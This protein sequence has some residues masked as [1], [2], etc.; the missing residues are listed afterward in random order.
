MSQGWAE[1][2]TE[3]CRV[4]WLG[5]C[6]LQS[7]LP[8]SVSSR[9]GTDHTRVGARLMLEPLKLELLAVSHQ[10]W[11]LGREV[12]S[13]LRSSGRAIALLT[14][15]PSLQHLFVTFLKLLPCV[16]V[17]KGGQGTSFRNQ[18]FTFTHWAILPAPNT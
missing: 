18:S 8:Q 12:G 6:L 7:S 4:E 17:L 10:M 1:L 5:I 11:V 9:V 15:E 2:Q 16:P 3:Q 13:E 14:A